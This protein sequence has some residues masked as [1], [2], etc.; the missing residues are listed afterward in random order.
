M[1]L[2]LK[3]TKRLIIFT[4]SLLVLGA[5]FALL[6]PFPLAPLKKIR[7]SIFSMWSKWILKV[8]SI[9][10]HDNIFE[11][12]DIPLGPRLIVSNHVSYLDIPI[13]ASL[14]P[15]LF[16]AKKEVAE[17]P[18]MGWLGQC[19]GMIFVD[20]NRLQLRAQAIGD[21][22]DQI[23]LGFNVVV[24]PEGTTSESGPQKGRVPFYG[25]AFRAA[26]NEQVPIE[27]IY[28]E[29][30]HLEKCA[31]V[32]DDSFARHLWEFLK[33]DRVDVKIRREWIQNLACREEQRVRFFDTRRWLLE[34]GHGLVRGFHSPIVKI[35]G[36]Y[37]RL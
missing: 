19:L 21:I 32:G 1:R 37:L 27:V 17:W 31:W 26:R 6:A 14:G 16:L 4:I 20:R 29:Y 2:Q 25:G 12:R 9:H 36:K 11:T 18:L 30:S 34:G 23:R 24:F 3:R 33:L 5:L 15:T 13:L 35:S 8:F 7:L 22:Q 28:L 10:I